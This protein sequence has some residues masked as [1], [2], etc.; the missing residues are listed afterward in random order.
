MVVA[1]LLLT[2]LLASFLTGHA[3]AVSGTRDWLSAVIF[4]IVASSAIYVILD[5]EYPRGG[6]IRVDSVDQLL[7]QTMERME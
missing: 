6:L 3:M 4:A 1:L 2:V 7:V 5:Y